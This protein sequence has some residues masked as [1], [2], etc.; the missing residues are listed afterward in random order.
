MDRLVY[1]VVI[2]CV[3]TAIVVVSAEL[4][5]LT[6]RVTNLEVGACFQIYNDRPRGPDGILPYSQEAHDLMDRCFAR[7]PR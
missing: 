5:N 1:L 6:V 3:T 7:I 4:R 2:V